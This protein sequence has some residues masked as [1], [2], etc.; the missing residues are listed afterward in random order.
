MLPCKTRSWGNTLASAQPSISQSYWVVLGME[1]LLHQHRSDF[2]LL[3]VP[4]M[5]LLWVLTPMVVEAWKTLSIHVLPGKRK[6]KKKKHGSVIKWFYAE[7][8]LK[9]KINMN[10]HCW[11]SCTK[12][13]CWESNVYM[14]RKIKSFSLERIYEKRYIWEVKNFQNKLICPSAENKATKAKENITIFNNAGQI[15]ISSLEK[16]LL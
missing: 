10:V 4:E 6:D 14:R 5:V 15:I 8:I 3:V 11:E 9:R 12:K 1:L 2:P 16:S 7:N 13:Y